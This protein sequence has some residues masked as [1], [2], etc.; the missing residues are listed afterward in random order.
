M[1][2]LGGGESAMATISRVPTFWP[3]CRRRGS[4]QWLWIATHTSE[5]L[6]SEGTPDTNAG[7]SSSGQ[8]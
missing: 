7:R 5:P 8:K 4:G 2:R 3:A 6:E 1:K